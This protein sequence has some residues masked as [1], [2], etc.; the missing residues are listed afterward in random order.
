MPM[1]TVFVRSTG[2]GAKAW[3]QP[4][5]GNVYSRQLVKAIRAHARS[6]TV[7]DLLKRA[8]AE[9]HRIMNFPGGAR[10]LAHFDISLG[11]YH[12]YLGAPP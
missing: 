10:Q 2:L 9:V 1:D 3:E 6:S 11:G 4:V 12:L 7:E 5:S 8:Q